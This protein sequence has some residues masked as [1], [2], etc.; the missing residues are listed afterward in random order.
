MALVNGEFYGA[1]VVCASVLTHDPWVDP[2]S[3]VAPSRDVAEIRIGSAP[4]F[5]FDSLHRPGG[6]AYGYAHQGPLPSFPA[7]RFGPDP[8][9]GEPVHFVGY[10]GSAGSVPYALTTT[11]TVRKLATASDG[12]PIFT[13]RLQGAAVHGDSGSP[14]LDDQ[15]EVVGLRMGQHAQSPLR[16]R[17]DARRAESGLPGA[18]NAR[19]VIPRIRSRPPHPARDEDLVGPPRRSRSRRAVP[20][21]EREPGHTAAQGGAGMRSLDADA[22]ARS[23]S[24]RDFLAE[25]GV[26]P[27]INAA[28][29]YTR[30][31]GMRMHREVV[32][33]IAAVSAQCTRLD[34]VHR[35]VGARLA[36]LLECEAAMV[37]SGAAAALLLG[38]A[39][40]IMEDDPERI[41]RLPDLTGLKRDVIIQRTHR[42]LYDHAVRACGV[43]LVEVDTRDDLERAITAQTAMLLFLNKARAPR[44]DLGGG[45]RRR[46]EQHD[47]PTMIDA[48][49]DVPPVDTLFAHTRMGLDIVA[50]SGGKGLGGP[51]SAGLLLGRGDLGRGATEHGPV[52]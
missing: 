18:R 2:S 21:G 52:Q 34:D 25:L 41:R 36:A 50:I 33:A 22:V 4:D 3:A 1:S 28:G 13:I 39:A 5:P 30:F 51:Q 16:V 46:G 8:V 24:G 17:D 31:G 23:A 48:A 12:T 45:I 37:T 35:A 20:A 19:R 15:G 27:I 26:R 9:V 40:C 6:S 47:V 42:F 10:G 44:P 43:R 29:T 14:V 38:T 11:G 32:E 7:L 49:A